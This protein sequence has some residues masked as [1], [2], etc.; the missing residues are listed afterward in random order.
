MN[1]GHIEKMNER[2][3]FSEQETEMLLEGKPIEDFSE[4]AKRKIY[5]LGFDKWYGAIPR[6]IK[7]LMDCS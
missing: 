6:N 7:A 2:I 1:L 5:L 4:S 3:V